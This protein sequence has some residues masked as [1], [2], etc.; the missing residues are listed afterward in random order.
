M[1]K[2]KSEYY[3]TFIYY[4]I[5]ALSHIDFHWGECI[6]WVNL[7]KGENGMY[8]DYN[9]YKVGNIVTW[10]QFSSSYMAN[11]NA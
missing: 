8:N 10:I 4:L 6:R 5:L 9:D 3:S 7:N 11:T 1:S 2:Y